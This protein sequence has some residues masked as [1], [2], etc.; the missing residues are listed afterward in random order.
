ML[1]PQ[2]VILAGAKPNVLDVW[3]VSHEM[4]VELAVCG[5]G[6]TGLGVAAFVGIGVDA[7]GG[8]AVS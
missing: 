3:D 5:A 1:V 6:V 8:G 7:T 2:V 4:G